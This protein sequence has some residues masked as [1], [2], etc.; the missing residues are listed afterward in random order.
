MLEAY[1]D[2]KMIWIFVMNA[3]KPW[4]LVKT[5]ISTPVTGDYND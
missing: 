1:I 5:K 3:E 4:E 2:L